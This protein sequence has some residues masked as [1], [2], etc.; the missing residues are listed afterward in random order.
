M[1]LVFID[2]FDT[3]TSNGNLDPASGA[4]MF[5]GSG[6]ANTSGFFCGAMSDTASGVGWAL[7]TGVFAGARIAFNPVSDITYGIR[8]RTDVII[9]RQLLYFSGDDY[10]GGITTQIALT[11]SPSG[12]FGL[13]FNGSTRINTP[14][15]TFFPDTWHYIELRMK[16]SGATDGYV[17]LRVDGQTVATYSGIT[18]PSFSSI[19]LLDFV[20]TGPGAPNC[21]W[22]DMYIVSNDGVGVSG[23]QGDCVVQPIFPNADAGPNSMSQFGGGVG[24]FTTVS[25][26]V[27]DDDSSY[28]Y[29][30]TSGQKEMFNLSDIPGD[31]I[32]I[33]AI[34]IDARAKKDSAGIAQFKID[35][36]SGSNSVQSAPK[37]PGASY[38]RFSYIVEH[39]PSGA[40]WTRTLL[41]NASVGVEIV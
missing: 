11:A 29:S 15:N 7:Q 23:F 41:Q 30:N 32:D 18:T 3:Y 6:W 12:V 38:Q 28:V 40:P 34:Q 9:S 10:F 20:A 21:Y 13:E 1:S 19:N 22:D 17:E 8:F 39:D 5:K 37:T 26:V 14:V 16:C 35:L 4:T 25:E 27:A 36:T 2:G 24:H 33:L 31:I